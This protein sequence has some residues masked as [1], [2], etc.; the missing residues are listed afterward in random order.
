MLL[1]DIMSAAVESV[2]PSVTLGEAGARMRERG[3][4]HLV[5]MSRG[6]VVGALSASQLEARM[7]D[8]VGTVEDAMCRRVSIGTPEMT[9]AR[10]ARVMR[11]RPDMPLMVF[12]GRRLAGIVTISD[13]LEVLGHGGRR[14]RAP[15]KVRRTS[16]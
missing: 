10:A 12:D 3:I 7:A 1:K 15:V 16:R 5:V 2:A 4:H 9:V 6:R 14:A 13:L 8:G 11:G